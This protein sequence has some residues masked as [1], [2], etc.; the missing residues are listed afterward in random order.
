MKIEFHIHTEY[1]KDSILKLK[2]IRK[3]MERNNII[4]VI[5]DHDQIKGALNY[6]KLYKN[7]IIGEEIT[8]TEGEII[9]IFLKRKI[10]PKQSPEQTAKKIREQ[11]GLVYVPHP[12]D[13]MRRSALKQS[14][15]EIIKPDIIEVFNRRTINNQADA[16][17][18]E[19][20]ITNKIPQAVASDA[21]TKFGLAKT[22]NIIPN[23]TQ[24]DLNSPKKFLKKLKSPATKQVTSLRTPVWIHAYG[25]AIKILKNLEIL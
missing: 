11:K 3:I 21:H 9:G 14:N 24:T 15:L 5:T 4:P 17:A 13:T 12:F 25:K 2:T 1:S 20:A 19:Y 10:S 7:C 22:Y 16:K 18:Q 6:K 23:I 8:T